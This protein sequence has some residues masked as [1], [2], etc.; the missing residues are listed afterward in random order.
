[1]NKFLLILVLGTAFFA[2]GF[3]D[4]MSPTN[5]LALQYA[6]RGFHSASKGYYD[7]AISNYVEAIKLNPNDT[8]SYINLGHIYL[9]KGDCNSAITNFTIALALSPQST[10]GYNERGIAYSKLMLFDQAVADFTRAIEIAPGN[11]RAIYNRGLG[12]ISKKEYG[13]AIGDF[14]DG[15]KLDRTNKMIINSRGIAYMK[16]KR[17]DSAV[18]DFKTV[19]ALDESDSEANNNMAWLLSTCPDDAYRNGRK[20]VFFSNKA[21]EMAHWN[22]WYYLGTLAAAYAEAGD[23]DQ[24]IKFQKQAMD[25]QGLKTDQQPEEQKKLELY[26]QHKPFRDNSN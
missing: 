14:T 13:R 10:S 8:A 1:M 15:L 16:L 18:Q 12:Y 17:W 3:C 22:K 2:K 23:Y 9:K 24:A 6:E 4:A 25:L 26:Q 7:D 19:L 20:A 11:I 5:L 21:C